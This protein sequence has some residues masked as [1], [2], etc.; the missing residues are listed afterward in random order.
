MQMK[1]SIE[2]ILSSNDALSSK[3]SK[4]SDNLDCKVCHVVSVKAE[5]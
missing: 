2:V 3:R 5:G 4:C 1:A